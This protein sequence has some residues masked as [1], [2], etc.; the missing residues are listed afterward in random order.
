MDSDALVPTEYID[1]QVILLLHFWDL[2]DGRGGID[3]FE[4]EI[5]IGRILRRS[6]YMV[7]GHMGTGP[8]GVSIGSSGH[9]CFFHIDNCLLRPYGCWKWGERAP[10]QWLISCDVQPEILHSVNR[11]PRPS[12]RPLF[13]QLQ[14]VGYGFDKS[15]FDFV[16]LEKGLLF[17]AK[18]GVR[19]LFSSI[20][21]L[22]T[23]RHLQG[24]LKFDAI[25]CQD[26][27]CKFSRIRGRT[28]SRNSLGSTARGCSADTSIC[29]ARR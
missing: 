15:P 1:G 13:E 8:I 22:F 12:L 27:F 26:L 25:E 6:V 10:S 7:T 14:E 5:V 3:P 20:W 2:R 17:V 16:G 4:V 21:P 28:P 11:P 18:H 9:P 23:K 19:E 24:K 29:Q